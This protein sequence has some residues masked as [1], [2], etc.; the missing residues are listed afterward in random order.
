MCRN[1]RGEAGDVWEGGRRPWDPHRWWYWWCW[2]GFCVGVAKTHGSWP[3]NVAV[4][5]FN[6]APNLRQSVGL[7]HEVPLG[8]ISRP[9]RSHGSRP[10]ATAAVR[11]GHVLS[12]C[13]E[14]AGVAYGEG[15]C[16]SGGSG[17][18]RRVPHASLTCQEPIVQK[19]GARFELQGLVC[20]YWPLS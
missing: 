12:A 4:R 13:N 14:A 10:A 5:W 16:G 6:A 3:S 7:N 2:W 9:P 18:R 20:F 1:M 19:H 8:S 11:R 17:P 15:F